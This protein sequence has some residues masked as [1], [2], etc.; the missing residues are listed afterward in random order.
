MLRCHRLLR[1]QA[2]SVS[3]ADSS[4]PEGAVFSELL[5]WIG[6]ADLQKKRIPN[7]FLREEGG[8]PKG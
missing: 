8:V 4:L 1:P 5:L 7:A 6:I 3:F 2:P